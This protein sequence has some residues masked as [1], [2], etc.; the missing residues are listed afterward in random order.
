MTI[1]E[2]L[3]TIKELKPRQ[4]HFTHLSHEINREEVSASLSP[5]VSLAYDRL[6]LNLIK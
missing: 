6:S 1:R 5:N 3:A 4:S 2:A